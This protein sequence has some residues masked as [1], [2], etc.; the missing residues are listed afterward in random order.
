MQIRIHTVETDAIT[1]MKE[2][3][4]VAQTL[5]AYNTRGSYVRGLPALV[6]YANTG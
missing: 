6:S 5:I 4:K 1:E 3:E 2:T